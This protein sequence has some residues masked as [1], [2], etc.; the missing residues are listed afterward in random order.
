MLDFVNRLKYRRFLDLCHGAWFNVERLGV[1]LESN[2][3][4]LE[5][6]VAR[7]F[8]VCLGRR[9]MSWTVQYRSS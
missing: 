6:I 9:K 5:R 3:A 2:L 8:N 7:E 4:T 1:E